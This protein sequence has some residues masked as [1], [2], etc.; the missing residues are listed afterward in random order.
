VLDPSAEDAVR[1]LIAR[2]VFARHAVRAGGSAANAVGM[3]WL[4]P[5]ASAGPDDYAEFLWHEATH[6]A[7]WRARRSGA[8]SLSCQGNTTRFSSTS[9]L[10]NFL[11]VITSRFAS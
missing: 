5:P 9:R 3:T 1:F 4:R 2:L 7:P 10:G 8:A 11:G 6:Q